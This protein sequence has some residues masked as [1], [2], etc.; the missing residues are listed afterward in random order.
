MEISIIG[1]PRNVVRDP[2]IMQFDG[3]YQN[4]TILNITDSGFYGSFVAG[5]FG[6][7]SFGY[8]CARRTT[9]H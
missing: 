6:D 2:R 9:T 5:V 7:S 3:F 4:L 8:F 1:I